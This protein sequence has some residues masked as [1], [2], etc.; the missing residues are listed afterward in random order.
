MVEAQNG[1][2]MDTSD[3]E[4]VS[5]VYEVG[6]HILHTVAEENI[7]KVVAEIRSVIE[8]AG[9]NF[10][11]EG[12][13][14]LTKLAYDMESKE[15][16]KRVSNDR[17]FFGWLK[18]EA[19]VAVVATLD[20]ALKANPSILRHLIFQTVREETRARM[21]APTLREVKR[22]DTIKSSPR[23]AEEA[24][25]PVSEADLEKALSDITE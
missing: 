25:E 15:G 18:F 22:T 14:A 17:A 19:P 11:A 13:P 2:T 8:K 4:V 6:Y 24:S 23:R 21:K 1:Q 12:A 16:D 20:E 3:N 10:I 5:R 9:G 7:E